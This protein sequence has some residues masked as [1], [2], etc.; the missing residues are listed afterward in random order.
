MLAWLQETALTEQE[1]A[2]VKWGRNSDT[3]RVPTRLRTSGH[4]Y[5]LATAL[6]VL[7]RVAAP[8]R[9]CARSASVDSPPPPPAPSPRSATSTSQTAPGLT[10]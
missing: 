8:R 2:I 5:R 6:E 9:G 4:V 10:S 7:V 1:R 3:G